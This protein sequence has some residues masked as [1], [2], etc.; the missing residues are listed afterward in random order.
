MG[1]YLGDLAR[2]QIE[3]TDSIA[4]EVSGK[5]RFVIQESSVLEQNPEFSCTSE[6]SDAHS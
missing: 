6:K 2:L 1:K 3:L 4:S 5:Y